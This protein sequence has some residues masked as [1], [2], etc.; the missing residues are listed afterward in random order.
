MIMKK[1]LFLSGI[2]FKDKS[3]QVIRKTP[4]AYV[5]EGWSVD[6]IVA[7]DNNPS[8]NY[9]YEKEIDL[10]G[11]NITRFNWPLPKIRSKSSRYTSLLLSKISSTMT[12]VR[13]SYIAY[14]KIK[15]NNYDVIYGYE[16]QGVLAM[17]LIKPWLG[18]ETKKI[19]RF[20]GTFLN[21]MLTKKQYTRLIFNLDLVLAIFL[22]S[23]LIIMTN[24]GTQG[25]LAV[26]KIKRGSEHNLLFIS[27]GVDKN[28]LV[29]YEKKEDL[30]I[31]FITVSRLVKWKRVDRCILIF[32][33][34]IKSNPNSKAILNIVGEGSERSDLERIVQDLN[35]SNSVCFLGA[36]RQSD[37]STLLAKS[38][39]FLSTYH[40]SNVGNPLLEAIRANL[41]IVTL[42][43]GD[44]GKWIKHKFN[45][46][47]YDELGINYELIAKDIADFMFSNEKKHKIKENL[48]DFEKEN[49]FTWEERL[50]KEVK[51][52]ESII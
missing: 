29:D 47:I 30:D 16:L 33:E 27:N 38:D 31:N 3:I 41:L 4:E 15:E 17:Q 25:D 26:N 28:Y 1:I 12:I 24:D 11:V 42:N 35:I 8:G 46:L 44:T 18:K 6:Y 22:K 43:N 52:I 32:N 34:F 37:V 14:K 39:V 45:G 5:N 2:D 40:S 13:L 21:E 20:Q 19:S 36:V 10:S 48:K 9:F 49:L 51:L 7:R 50:S 23:D